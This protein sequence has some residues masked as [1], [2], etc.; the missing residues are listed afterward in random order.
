[1]EGQ[2]R[3]AWWRSRRCWRGIRS[4]GDLA[5]P[6]LGAAGAS[7]G[8]SALFVS[9][10]VRPGNGL[11]QRTNVTIP[12]MFMARL[13]FRMLLFRRIGVLGRSDS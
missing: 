5:K 13:A 4:S 8:L 10:V 1:M 11:L 12:F 2:A 9:D 3:S 6:A 7:V